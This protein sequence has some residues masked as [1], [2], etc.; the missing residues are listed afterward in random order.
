MDEE[1]VFFRVCPY[2]N[3]PEA[4]LR[5]RVPTS[6]S[7]WLSATTRQRAA[8]GL[9]FAFFAGFLGWLF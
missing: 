6:R 7:S 5:F 4:F 1:Q 9:F 8:G 2:R 3:V